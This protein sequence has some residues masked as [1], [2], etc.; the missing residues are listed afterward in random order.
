MIAFEDLEFSL[1]S[2]GIL[3]AQTIAGR[4]AKPDV[5]IGYL[6]I[7]DATPLLIAHANRLYQAEG[8]SV[9]QPVLF[10]SRAQ[11]SEAFVA[12]Q[13][14]VVH[15]LSPIAIWLRYKKKFPA[16]IVAWNHTNG[17][18]LTGQTGTNSV[19]ELG[20]K[21]VAVPFW[22]SIHNVV[23]QML[24]RDAGLKVNP[25]T[26]KPARDEVKLIVLP[27]PDMISA[28]RLFFC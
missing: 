27:P 2:F 28:H 13:V 9:Q 5:K 11:I 25:L 24:L 17:S 21:T 8:L 6:P 14:N 16:K 4:G 18:A 12:G 22:Y 19:S 23:V 10:R 20:G 26:D 7:T 15:L 1:S 3:K